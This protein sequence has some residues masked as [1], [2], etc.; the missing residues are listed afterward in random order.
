MDIENKAHLDRYLSEKGWLPPGMS[1]VS[2]T[3]R[4]G[5]SN[6]TAW[7]IFPDNRQWVIK[8]ALEKLR[9]KEDWHCPPGRISVE[10][11]AIEWLN[12]V[13]P[14]RTVPALVFH[15]EERHILGMEAVRKPFENLKTV[16][17]SGRIDLS[18]IESAGQ[19]LGDIHRN[20]TTAEARE[21]FEDRSYYKVLRLEPYY[22]FTGIQVPETKDFFDRLVED[23]LATRLTVVHGDY[24]PKNMLIKEGR[25]VLLDHEVMHF[26]D[27]AFDVGFMLCH[28]FS[29][30]IHLP[31]QRNVL[32]NS[33][34]SFWK[35]Y[36]EANEDIAADIQSRAVRH[37]IG[38]LLARVK[39]RS[40][41]DYLGEKSKQI[42]LET[43]ISLSK[44]PVLTIE[45][46]YENFKRKLA[47]YD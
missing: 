23:T 18:L 22:Q 38:C 39:G 19:V 10:A 16:L 9:V 40:P 26:G 34:L 30:S 25:L 29:K 4:G 31:A 15:D 5:V 11:R 12:S 36:S 21:L 45:H 6:R 17:L 14:E 44:E 20:G 27:P 2:E 32:L 47:A 1:T 13:L 24:S 42:Q 46:F 35:C 33:V 41:H 43:G 7:V 8:Q 28:L 3:L 37:T